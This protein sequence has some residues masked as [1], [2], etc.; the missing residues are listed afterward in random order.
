[1]VRTHAG[2]LIK[3]RTMGFERKRVVKGKTFSFSLK[4][5]SGGKEGVT[6]PA[7]QLLAGAP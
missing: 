7:F 6:A 1:M 5:S 3:F 2:Q 4:H